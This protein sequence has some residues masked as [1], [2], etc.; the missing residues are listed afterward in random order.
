M[1]Q[2]LSN[3]PEAYQNIVELHKDNLDSLE[4][5]NY[6]EDQWQLLGEILLNERTNRKTTVKRGWK[7]NTM[8]HAL[9]AVNTGTN[10]RN[11]DIKTV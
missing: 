4:K 5:P 3:L 6:W 10:Q 2:I 11:S 9:L 8:V 7:T 1:T